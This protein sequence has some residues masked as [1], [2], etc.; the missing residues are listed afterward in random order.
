VRREERSGRAPSLRPALGWIL[1]LAAA[2]L[3]APAADA[4][5]STEY[6]VKAALL[7]QSARFVEWPETAFPDAKAPLIVGVVGKD[8]F[9]E[10]LDRTLA[11]AS[12]KG[13]A[14]EV[15]RFANGD[16]MEPCHLLFISGS[17]SDRLPAILERLAEPAFRARGPLTVGD[18]DRFARG[19][20]VLRL[21]LQE[22]K[23][24][25]YVNPD[26]ADRAGL[27]ISSHLMKLA[28]IERD[29][30]NGKDGEGRKRP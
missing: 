7:L 18:V 20:G 11:G 22:K 26:A 6:Q 15:R 27:K 17:E 9:G 2:S 8:P 1:A 23:I 19:G 24:R 29:A 13:R 25:L 12:V 14:I 10:I 28:T 5:P 30:G 16:A 3:P 21:A 4:P